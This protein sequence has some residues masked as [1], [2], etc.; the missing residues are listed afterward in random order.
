MVVTA[1]L[2]YPA[3]GEERGAIS[4]LYLSRANVCSQ[5][6]CILSPSGDEISHVKFHM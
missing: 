4:F 3:I 1:T 2:V 6:L 5:Q